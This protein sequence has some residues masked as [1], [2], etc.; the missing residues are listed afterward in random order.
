MRRKP[1]EPIIVEAPKDEITFAQDAMRAEAAAIERAATLLDDA[2]SRAVALFVGATGAG[3]TVIVTGMGKSGLVGQKIAATLS[4]LGVPAQCVHPAEAAHG[5]L[6]RIRRQD[7]LLALSHSGET[8]EVVALAQTL[9]QD[10][11]AIIAITKGAGGSALERAA[12]VNLRVGDVAEACPLS[13]APTSSTTVALALGDA[14]ALASARRINFTEA[15]FARRHPGGLLGDMLRPVSQA[16]RFVV[17]ENLPIVLEDQR[18]GEALREADVAGRRPGALVVVN[19]AGQLAGLFTDGDLR[20]LVLRNDDALAKR[21]GDVMTRSPRT[22]LHT[23]I[24][25]DA[26]ALIREH[27]Q[28]EIPIVDEQGKPVGVLDVQD[29]IALKVVSE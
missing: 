11:L 17:G 10:G 7:V 19:S 6:G 2:F 3:G 25:R 16:L 29:L 18:V 26:A 14:L 8:A 4:S 24:I 9:R 12:T 20:R 28:D 13:L 23:A 22:L 21:M 5:D 27:R 1:I 15:D